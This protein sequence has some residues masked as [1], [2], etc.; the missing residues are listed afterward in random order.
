M[1]FF[2]YFDCYIIFL[3]K[4]TV[5]AITAALEQNKEEYTEIIQKRDVSLQELMEVKSQH[6]EKLEQIETTIRK[7]Q[8]SLSLKIQRYN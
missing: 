6:A 7:L 2:L 8:N 3:S 1:L 5:E 4:K